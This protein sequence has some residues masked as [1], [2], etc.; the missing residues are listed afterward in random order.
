MNQNNDTELRMLLEVL[1]VRKV[2]EELKLQ[3]SIA[4]ALLFALVE[5]TEAKRLVVTKS[6]QEKLANMVHPTQWHV[7]MD[8]SGG[9]LI[10]RQKPPAADAPPPVGWPNPLKGGVGQLQPTNSA[11]NTVH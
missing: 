4:H 6:L 7:L 1:G 9:D 2:N 11:K 3:L 8:E 10:I 5:E